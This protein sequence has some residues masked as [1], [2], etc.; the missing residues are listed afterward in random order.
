MKIN[1]LELENRLLELLKH[2]V[3]ENEIEIMKA[4]DH[5]TRLIGASSIFDSID[6]VSF[7]AEVEE[8][9][10]NEYNKEILLTSESAMS[11]RNSP[12]VSINAISKF[13]VETK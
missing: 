5:E 12:F 10:F 9:V 4:V 3:K 6:L 11:R 2:F 8:F 7:I 1:L 13:I